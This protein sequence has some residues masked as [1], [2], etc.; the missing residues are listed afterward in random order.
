MCSLLVTGIDVSPVNVSSEGDNDVCNSREDCKSSTSTSSE[1]ASA[2]RLQVIST[3]FLACNWD[4]TVADAFASPL[5]FEGSTHRFRVESFLLFFE[6]LLDVCVG[7]IILRDVVGV[8]VGVGV[9]DVAF[10]LSS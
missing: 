9:V 3:F 1:N 4:S 6:I 5:I 10:L 7:G 8:G 2:I